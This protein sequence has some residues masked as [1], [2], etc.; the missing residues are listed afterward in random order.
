LVDPY[1][2]EELKLKLRETFPWH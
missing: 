1:P 2:Y